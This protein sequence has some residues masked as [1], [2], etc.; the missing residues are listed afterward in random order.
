MEV[1]EKLG[2]RMGL[3]TADVVV[4]V[5]MVRHH[6]LLPDVATRRDL[7]DPATIEAVASAVGSRETLDL[8]GALTEADSLATGPSAWG[9]WKAGL[10][11]DLVARTARLLAGGP[12]VPTPTLP[13]PEHLALMARQE[14]VVEVGGN[15]LTVVAPDRPG[16]FARVAGTLA[17]HGLDVRSAAVASSDD[18][19]AVEVFEVEPAFDN[20]PDWEA[21]R[22][23][24]DRALCGRLAVDARLSD[25]ARA[26]ARRRP[27]AARPAEPRVLFDNEASEAATVVEVRAP[28]AVGVLYRITRALAE[29]DLD[30]RRAKV[31]TMGHEVVDAF[32]VVDAAGRK[33]DDAEHLAEVERAVLAALA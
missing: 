32:Y 33:V 31:S 3:A 11:A 26:Y 16:L 18:G 30:V 13:T 5:D 2:T 10:V 1:V 12:T 19:M 14:L 6:L 27:A 9:E 20:P 21:L 22:L 23:D 25:R 17:L 7:D 24:V 4:L 28:D 8:L 29:V 15:R